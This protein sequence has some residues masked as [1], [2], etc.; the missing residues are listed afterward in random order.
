MLVG[1]FAIPG[2][3]LL[4]VHAYS[5]RCSNFLTSIREVRWTTCAT[6]L[7]RATGSSAPARQHRLRRSC[8]WGVAASAQA[9]S[10]T[11]VH[12]PLH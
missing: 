9:A 11:G 12:T 5:T 3:E 6:T 1:F 2:H 10:V 8:A 4:C 7:Q